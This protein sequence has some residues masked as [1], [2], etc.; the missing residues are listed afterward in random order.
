MDTW[1]AIGAIILAAILIL[2]V[3]AIV[4]TAFLARQF[5]AEDREIAAEVEEQRAAIRAQKE[6]FGL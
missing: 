3:A 5:A 1:Q 4:R 2:L 6:R